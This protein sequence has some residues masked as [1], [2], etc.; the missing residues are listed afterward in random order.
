MTDRQTDIQTESDGQK[1]RG[2]DR[3]TEVERD[4]DTRKR[5]SD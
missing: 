1:H 4:K 3:E 2:R 5:Q